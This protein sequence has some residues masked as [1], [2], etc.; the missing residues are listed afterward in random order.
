MA[1]LRSATPVGVPPRDTSPDASIFRRWLA[2]SAGDV[3]LASDLATGANSTTP[4]DHSGAPLGCQLR[5]PLAAQHIGRIVGN[6]LFNII[7]VP[8]PQPLNA[9]RGYDLSY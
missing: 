6:V 7:V 5:M 4:I 8:L 1:R 2:T 9:W 3:A